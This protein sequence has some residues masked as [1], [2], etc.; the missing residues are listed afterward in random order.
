MSAN[1][2]LPAELMTPG[3]SGMS[4]N[5]GFF[6]TNT[7]WKVVGIIIIVALLGFNILL[8]LGNVVDDAGEVLRPLLQKIVSVFGFTL[9]ETAK[10]T[11]EV[12]ADGTKLGV[13]VVAGT[14]KSAIDVVE[15]V[16]EGA[17][18]EFTKD[19]VPPI[20]EKKQ[21]TSNVQGASV[22]RPK[23]NKGQN[24]C[25]VGTDRG[26]RTCVPV[27]SDNECASGEIFP[28]HDVCVH[29]NLRH[30]TGTTPGRVVQTPEVYPA[31]PSFP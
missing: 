8:Y 30:H 24:F 22:N 13:D 10:K 11:V 23:S 26:N 15:D 21:K 5:E 31:P 2:G 7:T 4:S 1:T 16:G 25:Y 17:G 3:N 28:S 29:P 20:Q 14:L 19:E 18:V 12:S 9:T 27:G 6:A